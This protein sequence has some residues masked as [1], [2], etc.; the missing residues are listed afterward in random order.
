LS[1]EL[2]RRVAFG[3]VAAPIAVA[4]VLY[5]GA[6]LAA[7]LAIA[8]AIAAW[9]FFRLAR[10]TGLTPLD[11][12]G[13]VIAGLTPLVVHARFLG[14]YEPGSSIGVLSLAAIVLLAVLA[15]TIWIRGVAEKPIGAVST[16]IFG[17]AY[18]GG[19]LSFGYAIRYHDYAFA[20][21]SISLGR[22]TFGLASGGL[23]LLLPVLATWASDTGAYAVGRT[24]GRHKLLPSV[25]PGKTIEGSVGGL[26]G[27]V[28]VT[29]LL[30]RWLLRPAAHLDFRW[31]PVG[32]ILFGAMVSAVGQVGD[33][34]KSLLKRDAGVKD[35]STLI[36][37]HGGVLDRVDSLLFVLPVSYVLFGWLLTWA[38]S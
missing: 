11:D 37:G 13:I 2:A 28:L 23:L 30:T 20:P 3:V 26:L 31:A 35:S 17:A 1:S 22:S 4:I 27:S 19:M 8:S 36:P 34:A 10:A 14:L 21:A 25:S 5:G 6:A 29:W 18:T 7:L 9:E 33:L 32:V 16:T 15:L 38:P 24:M 12:V